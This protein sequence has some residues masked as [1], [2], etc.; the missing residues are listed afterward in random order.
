MEWIF[1]RYKNRSKIITVKIQCQLRWRWHYQ[2]Y[3]SLVGH[4]GLVVFSDTN[5]N[6]TAATTERTDPKLD[7]NRVH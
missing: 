3:Q 4:F 1:W 2:V 7:R 5:Q 6:T